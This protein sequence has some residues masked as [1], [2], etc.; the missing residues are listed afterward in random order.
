MFNVR[1]R[2]A[3]VVTCVTA[4]AMTGLGCAQSRGPT[5]AEPALGTVGGAAAGGALGSLLGRGKGRTAAIVGGAL[6]GGIAGNQLVDKP[7]EQQQSEQAEAARDRAMQ[8]QLDYERQSMLQRDEVERQL[9][10]QRLFEQWK[11]EQG[12]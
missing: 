3:L 4:M 1:N 5:P 11:R 2:K 6:L 7:V 12:Y 10:K 8:R 9:Q